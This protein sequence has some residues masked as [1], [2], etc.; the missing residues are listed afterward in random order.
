M[1]P[2]A[3]Q[4]TNWPAAHSGPDVLL[5]YADPVLS[6]YAQPYGLTILAGALEEVGLT[7]EV[8]QP[9]LGEDPACRLNYRLNQNVPR[10]VGISFRNLDWAGYGAEEGQPA[11]FVQELVRVVEI[12]RSRGSLVVVGGSGFSI[13]PEQLLQTTRADLGFVGPCEAQFSEFCWRVLRSGLSIK[14]ATVGLPSA[15]LPGQ[16]PPKPQPEA[17]G[18]PARLDE[19]AV[20]F[21]LLTG[22]TIPL[23]TKSGCSL[24]CTYCVVPRIEPLVLRPWEEIRDELVEL[25]AAGLGRRL[26]IADGEFNLPSVER[27]ID[28]CRRMRAE[29]PGA[30]EWDCYVEAG[31]VTRELVEAMREAGCI[32]ISLTVDS[33]SPGPRRLFA[34]GTP[35]AAVATGVELCLEADMP[36]T[37]TMLFGGPGETLRTAEESANAARRWNER[38]ARLSISVGLRIY[39]NTPLERLA[40]RPEFAAFARSNSDLPWL[41]TFCSPIEAPELAQRVQDLLPPSPT[42]IY[43]ATPPNATVAYYRALAEAQSLQRNGLTDQAVAAY[44]RLK[45]Q[46]P[47]RP[48][49]ELGLALAHQ[50]ANL[51]ARRLVEARFPPD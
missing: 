50:S 43:T 25:V 30:L 16:R 9:F 41:G 51:V 38:G 45:T 26:F 36:I 12:V 2:V 17:L 35:V 14:A 18:A 1:I 22:G 7:A 3:L 21:A 10:I 46:H 24:G 47:G 20:A 40:A 44:A 33:A 29:F 42:T 8:F 31:F 37:V 4:S 13:A 32:G 5:V 23:R 27:A 39:P 48:E 15:I 19:E 34:K 28:L 11:D 49:L 6:P